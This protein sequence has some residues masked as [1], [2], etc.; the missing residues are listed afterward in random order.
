MKKDFDLNSDHSPIHLTVSD[1]IINKEQNPGLT[2][3]LTDWDYFNQLL[4]ASINLS[5]PLKTTI[6]L[7]EEL[8]TFTFSIQYAAWRSTPRIKRKVKGHNLPKK[9]GI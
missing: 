8:E 5:V 4:E 7:E 1:K 2:N 3:R 6:Q 9:L